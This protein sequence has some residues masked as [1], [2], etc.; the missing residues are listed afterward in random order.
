MAK[1]QSFSGTITVSGGAGTATTSSF[2]AL[3]NSGGKLKQII[4][5]P[6]NEGDLYDFQLENPNSKRIFREKNVTGTMD[7]DR[8]ILTIRGTHTLRISNAKS[9]GIYTY[10]L[11]FDANW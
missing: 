10:T 5:E 6:P 9:D 3:E 2:Y 8:D 7:R 4:I 1:L 11:V